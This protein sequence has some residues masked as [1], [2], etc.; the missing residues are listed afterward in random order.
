MMPELQSR[1][2]NASE[3]SFENGD[4]T[5]KQVISAINHI[6][7]TETNSWSCQQPTNSNNAWNLNISN[8]SLNNNNNKNN[9]YFVFACAEY[10]KRLDAYF[11]AEIGCYKNKKYRW[12]AN[13][14]HFHLAEIWSLIYDVESG[15]YNV[16]TSTCFILDYPVFREV[17]AASYWD[18]VVHHLVSGYIQEVAER[19][20]Y[21]NGDV[22][23]GNRK[24]HSIFTATKNIQRRMNEH[25]N[26]WIYKF[27]IQGFFM[28]I[29]REF[30]LKMFLYFE[31]I[32]R[33]NGYDDEDRLFILYIIRVLVLSDPTQNCKR[34]SP[35]EKWDNIP[36]AKSLFNNNGCGFPIGN[37]YSQL[38]AVLL[39]AII[40]MVLHQEHLVDDYCCIF[41]TIEEVRECRV[42]VNNI[43]GAMGIKIHPRKFYIQPVRHGVPFCGRFIY[44]N[45]VYIGNRIVKM[46]RYK[47]K[48]YATK[49][50]V[51]ASNA[52]MLQSCFNSY[53][54]VLC[55]LSAFNIQKEMMSIILGSE[56]SKIVYFKTKQNHIICEIRKEFYPNVQSLNVIKEIDNYIKQQ[57][58]GSNSS[59]AQRKLPKARK[60]KW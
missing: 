19:I 23:H 12:D 3:Q 34:N 38:L 57:F 43:A 40:D 46:F 1:K 44:T 35:I 14:C 42:L 33:P 36:K 58:Y 28:S 31:S 20:H 5:W 11:R 37:F 9:S 17:F 49:I 53:T 52:R 15:N 41:D 39:L 16:G 8:G 59:R 30:A 32:C 54:G 6:S 2:M 24:G 25:P 45:R 26:G 18:R 4:F 21:A 13:K 7:F 55:H 48:I 27:D 51:N 56:W 47:M 22:S 50:D 10:T 29:N 60:K